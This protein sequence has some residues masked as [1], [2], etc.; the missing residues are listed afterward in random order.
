MLN[1]VEDV[2]HRKGWLSI[3]TTANTGLVARLDEHVI[4]LA[5]A[6]TPAPAD[7]SLESHSP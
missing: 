6:A 1:E 3:N 7:G 4:H 2:A 5:E